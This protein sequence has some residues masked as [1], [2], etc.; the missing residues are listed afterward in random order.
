M[1]VKLPAR[2]RGGTGL[3]SLPESRE[4]HFVY[5]CRQFAGMAQ[6]VWKSAEAILG[7]NQISTPRFKCAESLLHMVEDRYGYW[8]FQH[9]MGTVR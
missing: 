5:L 3:G 7:I 2:V 9:D 1:Y 6:G 8:K 4:K